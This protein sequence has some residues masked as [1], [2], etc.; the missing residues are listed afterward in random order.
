MEAQRTPG[1]ERRN[2]STN[3]ARFCADD[4][5]CTGTAKSNMFDNK[6]NE[7]KYF[8]TDGDTARNSSDGPESY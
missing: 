6:P 7:T 8:Y 3:N 2:C 4:S 1:R 5:N